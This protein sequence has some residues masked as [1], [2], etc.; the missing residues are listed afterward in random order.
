MEEYDNT[1]V[2]IS[3]LQKYIDI[4]D[5]SRADDYTKWL[6]IGMI[7]YNCN[8]TEKCLDLWDEWSKQSSRYWSR[9]CNAYKWNRFKFGRL[10]M[11]TLKYYAKMDTPD[12]YGEVE[13]SLEKPD[14]HIVYLWETSLYQ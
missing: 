7:L 1:N 11:G 13:Y 12:K 5:V 4:L 2:P 6:E 14:L 8:P 3:T 10:S 9:D